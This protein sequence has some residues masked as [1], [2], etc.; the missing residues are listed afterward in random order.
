LKLLSRITAAAFLVS[1]LSVRPA[2]AAH[3]LLITDVLDAKEVELGA[4]LGYAH[5]SYDRN[6]TYSS[7]VT[8]SLGIS[9]S[10]TQSFPA[11]GTGNFV[12]SGLWLA[13]GIGG[14]LQLNASVPYAFE[15]NRKE[16]LAYPLYEVRYSKRDG[17]GDFEFGVKYG[18][19]GNAR[20]S[21]AVVTGLDVKFETAS[22]RNYGT[23]TTEVSPF[24]AASDTVNSKFREYAEYRAIISNHGDN[25]SHI[26]SIGSEYTFN[27]TFTVN[28]GASVSFRTAS[29]TWTAYESFN[30]N[31]AAYLQVYR[32]FY[33]IPNTHVGIN[34][35]TKAKDGNSSIEDLTFYGAGLALYYLY[36]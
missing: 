26:I 10:S 24:I 6:Y 32:N 4:S 14:G 23:G 2:N 18:L 16:D 27:P 8:D 31:L 9:S 5:N 3:R 25:D 34:T 20:N 36:D 33:L 11:K 35:S 28:P 12:T 15:G 1:L 17:W 13:V 22:T 7:S 30:L 29:R 21:L 19:Y